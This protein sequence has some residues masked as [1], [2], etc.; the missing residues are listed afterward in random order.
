M[1]R[2]LLSPVPEGRAALAGAAHPWTGLLSGRPASHPHPAASKEA[3]RGHLEAERL[4]VHLPEHATWD[5]LLL[6]LQFLFL[7]C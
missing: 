6:V 4:L 3:A 7:H 2:N 5:A 1:G